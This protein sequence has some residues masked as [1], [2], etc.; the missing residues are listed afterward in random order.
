[1][2]V[3]VR[4]AVHRDR[5]DA[6][7]AARRDNPQG[8][9]PAV[10]DENLLKHSGGEPDGEELLAVL[11]GLSAPRIDLDDLS[12][13]VGLD[14]VHQLHRLDDAEDLALRDL[15]A[16][17]GEG[18]G[19][20]RGGAVEGPDDRGRDDVEVLVAG[21]LDRLHAV[22]RRRGQDRSAAVARGER[23]RGRDD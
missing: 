1:E 8:D 12:L 15:L 2:R 13:D 11:D 9:L 3:A 23:W 17:L 20:G 22:N 5:G 18:I 6:E 4:L 7:L 10:G 14:L 21:G 16:D 19:L